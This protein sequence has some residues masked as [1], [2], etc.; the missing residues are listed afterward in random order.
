LS[1]TSTKRS[2]ALLRIYPALSIPTFRLTWAG[3]LP[4]QAA[5]NMGEV[6]TPYAAF[7]LTGSATAIGVVSLI[8]GLPMML[9]TLVGGVMADRLPRR[10]I[11]MASQASAFVATAILTWVVIGGHLEVWH[12]AAFGAVQSTLF[13]FNNPAYQAFIAELVPRPMVRSAI[14]VHMTG[15]NLARVGGPSVAGVLLAIPA[16]G[17]AGV[18]AGMSVMN[19]LALSSLI[20]LRS[21]HSL[22]KVSAPRSQRAAGSSW[23]QLTE[24]LRYVTLCPCCAVCW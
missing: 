19:A 9:F 14:A 12:L 3:M 1:S 23:G 2:N 17:L 4:S 20:R 11:L 8:A 15:F 6:A 18:Y 16:I 24:G 5:V 22:A 7:L 10:A 21:Y 13:A